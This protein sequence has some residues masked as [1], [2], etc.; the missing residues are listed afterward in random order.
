MQENTQKLKNE[1]DTAVQERDAARAE[2]AAVSSKLSAY[3]KK[4]EEAHYFSRKKINAESQRITRE[5]QITRSL[6]K[7]MTVI[8]AHDLRDEYNHTKVTTAQ[9]KNVLE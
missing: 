2:L 3:K 7:A 9:R 6:Q 8:D 4:E 5:E 1:R